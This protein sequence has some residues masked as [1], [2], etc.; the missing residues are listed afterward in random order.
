[1]SHPPNL[2]LAAM[3][4]LEPIFNFICEGNVNYVDMFDKIRSDSDLIGTRQIFRSLSKAFTA[5]QK[6]V[7]AVHHHRPTLKQVCR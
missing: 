1:M 7:E 4:V 3:R 6:M 5:N 2:Q